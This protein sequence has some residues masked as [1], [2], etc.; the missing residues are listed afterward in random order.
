MILNC[1]WVG[2]YCNDEN[3]ALLAQMRS[4]VSPTEQAEIF[5]E[6]Q[7]LFYEEVGAIKFGD[8]FTLRG[9]RSN[10]EGYANT[11]EPFFWNSWLENQ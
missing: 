8:R 11:P 10:V 1:T 2:F 6:V 4:T 3:D 9:L 5:K 7:R